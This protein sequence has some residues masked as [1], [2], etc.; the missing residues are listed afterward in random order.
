MGTESRHFITPVRKRAYEGTLRD[1]V[2]SYQIHLKNAVKRQLL[3]DVPVGM[4]LSGGIDSALIAAMAKD[5]GHRLP[6]FT[7]GFGNNYDECEI[8]SAGDTART[9]NLP[10]SS[11]TITPDSL[12]EALPEIVRAVEE[13]LGTTSIMPMWYLV[14]RAKQDVTVVLT[15]QGADEPWGGYRRYQVE[16]ISKFFPWTSFWSL[17]AKNSKY[18]KNLPEI[19]ERGLRTLSVQDLT[20]RMVA[21]CTLFT[22]DERKLLTGSSA[23]GNITNTLNSWVHWLEGTHCEPAEFMMRL[24]TRLNLA[25]DLLLYGD[26]ISMATA[27]EARVPMLDIQLIDFVESLPLNYRIAFR[28]TKIVHKLMAEQY[29][30]TSIVHRKK[31]GFQVPFA[32][33]SRNSWRDYIEDTLLSPNAPH[34]SYINKKGLSTLWHEHVTGKRNRSRQ[35]FALL[36]LAIWWRETLQHKS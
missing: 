34:L 28:Q 11:I 7:V 19:I 25:D 30:P 32:D 27:L 4:L 6:C 3:S 18:I 33:W 13:P 17:A 5:L 36:M 14:H 16:M 26:K 20:Q 12:L 2:N 15:G 35:I 29:L 24:D 1:A 21:A 23:D 22:S 8:E 31:F 10:I 9:L